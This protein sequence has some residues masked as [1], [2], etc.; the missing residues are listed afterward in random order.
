[1]KDFQT[2]LFLC[3]GNF[4]RSRFAEAWFN[5]HARRSGLQWRAES[6]GFRPHLATEDLSHCTAE[7]LDHSGV[8][9]DLTG[10]LPVKVSGE[11]LADA[12]LVIALKQEEHHPMMLEAFPLRANRIR[13]WNVSDIDESPPAIA[14]PRIE[15]E[16][17]RLVLHL[18]RG[19]A[20]GVS[21]D[22]VVEF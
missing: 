6:R 21:R 18:S 19:H 11:D 14:L 17:E 9:L 3:T 16:V 5:H 10:P 13:Y 4:Y 22:V 8:P 7:R 2:V 20:L 1:M 15:A 12:S